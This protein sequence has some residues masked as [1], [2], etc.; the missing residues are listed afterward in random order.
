[1]GGAFST[2]VGRHKLEQNLVEDTQNKEI[3]L[4]I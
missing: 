2:Y 3:T 1:M 4:K